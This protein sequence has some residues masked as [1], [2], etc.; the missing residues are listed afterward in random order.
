MG[1]ITVI[2]DDNKVIKN[3]QEYER[4]LASFGM[5]GNVA[6]LQWQDSK[7]WLEYRREWGAHPPNE[8]IAALP[9]WAQ[10]VVNSLEN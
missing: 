3:G 10:A 8:E 7:G 4:D 6:V 1:R 9:D 2:A 5:P